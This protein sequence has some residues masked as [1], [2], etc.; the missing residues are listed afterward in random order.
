MI[1]LQAWKSYSLRI[2]AAKADFAIS[3]TVAATQ[4]FE[5]IDLYVDLSSTAAASQCRIGFGATATPAQGTTEAT[6]IEG[7]LFDSGSLG[8]GMHVPGIPGIGGLNQEL[9]ITNAVPTGGEFNITFLG[10][11]VPG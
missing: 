3:P 7:I 4:R 2:T 6:P 8:A 11:I 5:V 1:N 10:R 9:R